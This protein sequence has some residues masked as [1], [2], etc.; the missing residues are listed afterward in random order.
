[1][2]GPDIQ[3]EKLF[4][5]L[6]PESRASQTH[7]LRPIRIMADK[8]LKELSPIFRELYSRIGRPSIPPEQLLRSLLL[9]I[10][11]LVRSE[12]ILAEQL[13]YNLLFRWFVGLSMDETIWNHSVY[14]K[15]RE[16]ILH[17]D[18]AVMFLRSI[19]SQALAAGLLSGD[20]FTVDD[21]LIKTRASLKSFRPK[22]KEPPIS[23]GGNRNPEVDFHGE[24]CCNDTHVSVTDPKSRLFRK[25]KGKE[26]KLCFMGYVLMENRNGLAV[27]TRATQATGTAER[28]AR[29]K[30]EEKIDW[31][32][33]L[34]AA[35]CNM[36]RMRSLGVVAS[37]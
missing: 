10:L 22:D 24:K 21:T 19:C 2:R 32:F 1:M 6:S 15:N 8:A 28:G 27:D 35:A 17:S 14:S 30:G 7:P 23:T 3:Q 18:L 20:H 33:T 36:V 13:D 34:S 16:R 4:S 25:G 5:Y 12:R 37:G 11:Y 9:Q 26:A 29:Y 31:L